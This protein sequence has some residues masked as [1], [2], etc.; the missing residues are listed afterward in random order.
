MKSSVPLQTVQLHP[1]SA[2]SICVAIFICEKLNGLPSWKTDQSV[3]CGTKI[4]RADKN[5][6]PITESVPMRG[7]DFTFYT[8][9]QHKPS[10][11]L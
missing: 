4:E 11:A 2:V 5:S 10:Q 3:C 7:A 8:I 1:L 6:L 9:K